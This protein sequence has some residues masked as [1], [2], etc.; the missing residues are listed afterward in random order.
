MEC[1]KCIIM[2]KSLYS[3]TNLKN[4]KRRLK[5]NSNDTVQHI[6]LLNWYLGINYTV[7]FIAVFQEYT[8]Y[9]TK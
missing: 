7:L 2:Y 3:S 5:F 8:G 4:T 1:H 9:N 6:A